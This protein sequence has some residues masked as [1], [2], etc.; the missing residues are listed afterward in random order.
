M[1]R[2]ERCKRTLEMSDV[3][4]VFKAPFLEEKYWGSHKGNHP[5]RHT[6]VGCNPN[7]KHC[8]IRPLEWPK[9][10]NHRSLCTLLDMPRRMWVPNIIFTSTRCPI[11]GEKAQG[12]HWSSCPL[13]STAAAAPRTMQGR[14]PGS[15]QHAARG[16]PGKMPH[17]FRGVPRGGM[18][19]EQLHL[20]LIQYWSSCL[21]SWMWEWLSSTLILAVRLEACLVWCVKHAR[22]LAVFVG[23]RCVLRNIPSLLPLP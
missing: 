15:R 9:A 7:L 13:H 4:L 6:H 19:V 20:G 21:D 10:C 17:S 14:K 2:G 11:L 18:R 16:A 8:T 5:L 23:R 1:A 22:R 12:R 3:C